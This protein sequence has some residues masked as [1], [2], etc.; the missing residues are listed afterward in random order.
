MNRIK[1]GISGV[2]IT[3]MMLS[4]V[5]GGL[6]GNAEEVSAATLTAKVTSHSRVATP[7]GSASFA[8][9]IAGMD[10]ACCQA[11]NQKIP[12]KGTVCT[13][14]PLKATSLMTKI[15][16]VVYKEGFPGKSSTYKYCTAR[17]L[18]RANGTVKYNNYDYMA[19][20]NRIYNKAKDTKV[21][22]NFAAYKVNPKNG[23]QDF[24]CWKMIPNGYVQVQK[25]S[26]EPATAKENVYSF[27]GAQFT[28]YNSEGTK[29]G[30]LTA[31]ET[32]ATNKLSVLPG[33]YTIKETKAPAGY[34]LNTASY[35]VTVKSK[36]VSKITISDAPIKSTINIIKTSD[37]GEVAGFKFNIRNSTGT[38]NKNHTTVLGTDENSKPVGRITA[39]LNAGTYTV[40]EV[41]NE[42]QKAKGYTVPKPQTF[43]VKPG[44]TADFKFHNKINHGTLKL[45]KTSDT[46]VVAGFNFEVTDASGFKEVFTTK[47]WVGNPDPS[48][49]KGII[50]ETLPPGTYTIKE[51]LSEEQ[52][53]AGYVA[54]NPQVITIT[55]GEVEEVKFHNIMKPEEDL[56]AVIKR[57]TDGGSAQGF[58]F[59]IRGIAEDSKKTTGSFLVSKSNPVVSG[60]DDYNLT[61]FKAD[62]A[63]LAALNRAAENAQTGRVQV[64][65][66]AS[67]TLKI[68]APANLKITDITETEAKLTWDKIDKAEKYE[69]YRAEEKA[70]VLSDYTKVAEV[71]D[72]EY[73][74]D[75]IDCTDNSLTYYMYK[76]KALEDNFVS[77]YSEGIKLVRQEKTLPEDAEWKHEVG[78]AYEGK[79]VNKRFSF[80]LSVNLLNVDT[81]AADIPASVAKSKGDISWKDIS[82]AVSATACDFEGETD[83][84]GFFTSKLLKKGTYTVTEI[85]TDEQQQ[86]Y[87]QPES[88][89]KHLDGRNNTLLFEFNNV[90]KKGDVR[91]VKTS[92]DNIVEGVEFTISGVTAWGEKYGPVKLLTVKDSDDGSIGI[93]EHTLPAGTYRIEETGLDPQ[94]YAPQKA[95]EVIITGDETEP[96][97]VSFKNIPYKGITIY[98]R[99]TG[100]DTKELPGAHLQIIHKKTGSVVCDFITTDKPYVADRLRQGD[101]YIVRETEAP[102][103]YAVADDIEFVA[104]EHSS[105]V[106]YDELTT[107]YVT[108]VD[109]E[110]KAFL[111][112]A[113]FEIADPQTNEKVMEFEVKMEEGD[114]QQNFAIFN[115]RFKQRLQAMP[116]I[117]GYLTEQTK[118]TQ[119][120][121]PEGEE[122]L[123][124]IFPAEYYTQI[125]GLIDG[126]H[127]VIREIKTPQGYCTMEDIEFVFTEGMKLNIENSRPEIATFASDEDPTIFDEMTDDNI[128]SADAEVKLIDTVA[129][130]GL[131]PGKIYILKSTFVDKNTGKTFVAE[132]G[133]RLTAQTVFKPQAK[134]GEIAVE[135]PAFDGRNFAGVKLVAYEEIS[136]DDGTVIAEHNEMDDTAQT[137]ILLDEEGDVVDTGDS[138]K[139]RIFIVLMNASLLGFL[140]LT[141]SKLRKGRKNKHLQ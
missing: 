98:K 130:K 39:K 22:E 79:P 7:K 68:S 8:Y 74:D 11:G 69:V 132:D 10:G 16:Y 118:T 90:A 32:G 62:D 21:P 51:K 28:V 113:A 107:L 140:G 66:S 70:G 1:R 137:I 52:E 77:D 71:A 41:L 53:D 9:K 124:T 99:E 96:V 83:R 87:H 109:A 59:R 122:L 6:F 18:G 54:A 20:V 101:T 12:V 108:K 139:M 40:T 24:V 104:G 2:I 65:M 49:K 36:E 94:F 23:G 80:V 135:F 126:K 26:T 60:N 42:E 116:Y 58:K 19:T 121:A 81:V 89:T 25:T 5:L 127:Y 128:A 76:V 92:L 125:N 141:V 45:I 85:L 103:G 115:G 4:V 29:K 17:A 120:T 67:A 112:G 119:K 27:T 73:I 3:V 37:T 97:E 75:N 91:I 38:Y 131:E 15:A 44:G 102:E 57:T 46:D 95:K 64:K 78:D 110:T 61:E 56:I 84:F 129:Y 114:V 111:S 14:Q 117:G 30:V 88:Q 86:R 55:A 82:L 72:E 13:L 133:T 93:I 63:D 50:S 33:T 48:V 134:D 31:T 100:D 105:V 35:K 34:R 106:M 136:E 138:T 47:E 123:E 43:T